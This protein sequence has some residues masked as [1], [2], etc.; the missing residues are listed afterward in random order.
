MSVA[1]EGC[2]PSLPEPSQ[3]NKLIQMRLVK[4]EWMVTALHP[5]RPAM[6]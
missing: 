3:M 6:L 4:A 5:P 1:G 2:S